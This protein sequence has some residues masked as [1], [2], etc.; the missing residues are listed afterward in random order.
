MEEVSVFDAEYELKY[1]GPKQ[2]YSS[3]KNLADIF[4][5]TV[6]QF[7]NKIAI[8]NCSTRVTYTYHDVNNLANNATYYLNTMK[9]SDIENI[10]IMA[11]DQVAAVIA[12]IAIQKLGKCYVPLETSYP[13]K[14][15]KNIFKETKVKIVIVDSALD[16]DLLEGLERLQLRIVRISDLFTHKIK[17]PFKI[18][19]SMG[20]CA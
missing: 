18:L 6:S 17:N 3:Y 15:L 7:P 12:M 20:R 4:E 16:Q 14:L 10:A 8:I 1:F 11:N 5:K 9:L 19:Y 13:I 2:D